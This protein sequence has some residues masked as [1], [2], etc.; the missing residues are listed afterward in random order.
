MADWY[1]SARSNY[2]RVRNIEAF[3]KLCERWNAQFWE[4]G[5]YDEKTKTNKKTGRV[6]FSGEDDHGGLPYY[7]SEEVKLGDLPPKKRAAT[8]K[9]QGLDPKDP[10]ALKETVEVE[11]EQDDFFNELAEQLVDGEVAVMM[12]AGAEKL[13]YVSGWAIAINSKGKRVVVG[14]DDIYKKAQ[15]LTMTKHKVSRCGN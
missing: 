7:R 11:Y 6:A 10:E 9:A 8:A 4:E 3:K 2:F 15:K 13:R 12:E 1:G 5:K 14:L